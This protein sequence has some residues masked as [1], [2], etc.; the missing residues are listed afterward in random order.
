MEVNEFYIK[1]ETNDKFDVG[2][3]E[4][5][6]MLYQMLNHAGWIDLYDGENITVGLMQN[7]EK[8]PLPYRSRRQKP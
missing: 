5:E 8:T 6:Q 4:L 1:I 7:Y 2:A 3:L